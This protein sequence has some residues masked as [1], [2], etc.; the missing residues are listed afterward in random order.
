MTKQN[1]QQLKRKEALIEYLKNALKN[2][3]GG[4]ILKIDLRSY[5]DDKLE[6]EYQEL[7]DIPKAK[8]KAVL[9][10]NLQTRL[11]KAQKD[12]ESY[13]DDEDMFNRNETTGN[14]ETIQRTD[15]SW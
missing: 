11:E 7:T 5:S 6:Y 8:I 3:E 13:F 10:E 2:I 9:I 15:N 14:G 12:W 4:K 1:Y